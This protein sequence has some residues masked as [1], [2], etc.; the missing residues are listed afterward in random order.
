MFV[1]KKEGG[2][3][4]GWEKWVKRGRE[5]VRKGRKEKGRKGERKGGRKGG[6]EEGRERERTLFNYGNYINFI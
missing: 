6:W 3:K 2:R 5:R 1:S 4:G